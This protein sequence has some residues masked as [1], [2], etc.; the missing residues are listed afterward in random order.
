LVNSICGG[1]CACYRHCW[2]FWSRSYAIRRCFFSSERFASVLQEAVYA[3]FYIANWVRA[4]GAKMVVLEHTWSLS[5][6]EQF[7]VIWPLLMLGLFRLKLG[8]KANLGILIGGL[9]AL[10]VWRAVLTYSGAS[11][12][13][14]YNGFDVHSD[15]LLIGCILGYTHA[16][17]GRDGLSWLDKKP[18]LFAGLLGGSI[19][20]LLMF[21][22]F[23]TYT[24]P[25]LYYWQ[26]IVISICLTILLLATITLPTH[27][28]FR[29]LL[30]TRWLV[31]TGQI[32]YGLY[33]WHYPVYR[34][35]FEQG[36]SWPLVLFLGSAV[37]V[38]CASLSFYTIEKWFL[39]MKKNYRPSIPQA[40]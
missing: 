5:I 16:V 4:F 40:V 27:H 23:G 31:W 20:V 24:S 28:L 33:L 6:E 8:A 38:I 35:M 34:I 39:K 7:Y 36:M 22:L 9:L 26:F 25:Q 14:L 37:T 3:L 18:T 2:F 1:F 12:A 15:I 19:V 10:W 13:R 17:A 32:S 30:R 11:I 29:T 21:A